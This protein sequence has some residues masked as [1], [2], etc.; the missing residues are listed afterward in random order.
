MGRWWPRGKRLSALGDHNHAWRQPRKEPWAPEQVWGLTDSHNH[1]LTQCR[2]LKPGS[3]C[4]CVLFHC[5]SLATGEKTKWGG[6]RERCQ[7]LHKTHTT[8]QYLHLH[9]PKHAHAR[10]LEHNTQ[11][12][13]HTHTLTFKS[14][15][16]WIKGMAL[17]RHTNEVMEIWVRGNSNLPA[18]SCCSRLQIVFGMQVPKAWVR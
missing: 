5:R 6:W 13:T 8:V 12:H 7:N 18:I 15:Y 4:D 14:T 1:L 17:V 10:A 16:M 11:K 2:S 9:T 3:P